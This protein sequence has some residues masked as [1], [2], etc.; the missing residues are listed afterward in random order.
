VTA[1]PVY[2]WGLPADTQPLVRSVEGLCRGEFDV[3][4][5]TTVFN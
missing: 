4:I 2:Q 1:V 5:F 3:A